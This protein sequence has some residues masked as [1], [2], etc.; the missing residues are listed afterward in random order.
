M[1]DDKAVN[2]DLVQGVDPREMKADD[3]QLR[4]GK[5]RPRTE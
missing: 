3:F 2:R 5:V 1:F 4:G